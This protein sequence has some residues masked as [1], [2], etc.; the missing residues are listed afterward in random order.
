MHHERDGSLHMQVPGPAAKKSASTRQTTTRLDSGL[1]I[2]S[3]LT[4]TCHDHIEKCV[5]WLVALV[6]HAVPSAACAVRCSRE[7]CPGELL[8][9][10]SPMQ[11]V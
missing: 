3:F 7:T 4:R 1:Y 6:A 11:L 10:P 2:C 8:V 5:S 9:P